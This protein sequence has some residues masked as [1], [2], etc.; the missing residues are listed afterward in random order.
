MGAAIT[1]AGLLRQKHPGEKFDA[2]HCRGC[3]KYHAGH[4]PG[5]IARLI[6]ER[7]L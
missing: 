5:R 4:L 6:E 1:A 2:W 3:G 7:T